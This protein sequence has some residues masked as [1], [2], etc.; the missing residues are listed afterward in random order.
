MKKRAWLLFFCLIF[1]ISSFSYAGGYDINITPKKQE[2]K[3]WCWAA[4]VQCVADYYDINVSQSAVSK[5]VFGQVTDRGANTDAV[6]N[7]LHRL[8]L[9]AERVFVPSNQEIEAQLKAGRPIIAALNFHNGGGHYVVICGYDIRFNKLRYMDS[10]DG[11][12][13]E[14][15]GAYFR[16]NDNFY[17]QYAIT[18]IY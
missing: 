11:R 2:M 10:A 9:N 8:G 18:N 14:V 16:R 15:N 6:L 5:A 3:N 17:W 7:V 12:I 13:K 4:S 1:V